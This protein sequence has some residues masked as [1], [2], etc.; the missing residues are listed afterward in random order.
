[1]FEFDNEVGLWYKDGVLYDEEAELEREKEKLR[2]KLLLEE[3]NTCDALAVAYP[4]YY[5]VICD[6]YNDVID[7]IAYMSKR[8]LELVELRGGEL[9]FAAWKMYSTYNT[10]DDPANIADDTIDEVLGYVA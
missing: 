1:M 4:D 2:S 5:E 3:R 6:L 10:G 8:E 9:T 7:R